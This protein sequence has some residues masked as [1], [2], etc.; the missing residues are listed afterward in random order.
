MNCPVCGERLRET[1]RQGVDID[2]CP[3]C[4]GVWLDRGELDKIIDLVSGGNSER[5]DSHESSRDQE[6][7]PD[8]YQ[9]SEKSNHDDRCHKDKDAYGHG[10]RK[11]REGLLG[12][13][14]NIF[15]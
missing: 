13:I 5:Y 9:D 3:A 1:N 7:A 12:E 14:F 10:K 2:I 6:H 15:D 8:V 4:K 11:K